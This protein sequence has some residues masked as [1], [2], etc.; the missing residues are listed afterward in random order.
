METSDL[1]PSLLALAVGGGGGYLL[2]KN[3]VI[4]ETPDPKSDAAVIAGLNQRIVLL[5]AQNEA[6]AALV[7]AMKDQSATG[8]A[9]QAALQASIADLNSKLAGQ[10]VTLFTN[11]PA[12]FG[13]GDPA[14]GGWIQG[15]DG[16]LI[17]RILPNFIPARS[18]IAVQTGYQIN[19]LTTGMA[20]SDLT[21]K[22]APRPITIG[23]SVNN[24]LRI[25]H[26]DGIFGSMATILNFVEDIADDPDFIC[27]A[28]LYENTGAYPVGCI[29]VPLGRKSIMLITDSA[30]NAPAGW[31]HTQWQS[32]SLRDTAAAGAAVP[33]PP[34]ASRRSYIGTGL[35]LAL[36]HRTARTL[37]LRSWSVVAHP[38][39]SWQETYVTGWTD[40]DLAQTRRQGEVTIVTRMNSS[41]NPKFYRANETGAYPSVELAQSA[42]M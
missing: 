25:T 7:A 10:Q 19:D 35:N 17:S 32:N 26:K 15:R 38:L 33:L 30:R 2:G 41:V 12:I 16:L 8:Q 18:L 29:A 23:K 28:G 9:V 3:S 4:Q 20:V 5:Q 6:S 14:I 1:V 27:H 36:S 13:T 11:F 34:V 42:Y 39:A 24:S 31:S 37:T 22:A 40:D 21:V